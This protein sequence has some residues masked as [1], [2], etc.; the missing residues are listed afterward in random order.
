[1]IER[2]YGDVHSW[3]ENMISGERVS[4]GGYKQSSGEVPADDLSLYEYILS[5]GHCP[6]PSHCIIDRLSKSRGLRETPLGP[7][8]LVYP[9][10]GGCVY[11]PP[12]RPGGA[13]P[14][15]WRLTSICHPEIFDWCYHV[16]LQLRSGGFSNEAALNIIRQITPVDTH[17]LV[18]SFPFERVLETF[19]QCSFSDANK[20]E[21][22][23][24]LHSL[25][26]KKYVLISDYQ[27]QVYKTL[28]ML[29]IF[30]PQLCASAGMHYHLIFMNGL[31]L[32]TRNYLHATGHDK[33]IDDAVDFI[34]MHEFRICKWIRLV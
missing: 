9:R 31:S 16:R 17:Y 10:D 13:P 14:T 24:H 18:G 19:I 1:M 30:D 23:R 3:N 6:S 34:Q 8:L 11:F 27:Y 5:H 25:Y 28:K 22:V 20:A 21:L 12:T 2:N 32:N 26:Q 7:M 15:F 33:S 4:G 29:S